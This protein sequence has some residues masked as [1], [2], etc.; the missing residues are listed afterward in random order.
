MTVSK[1]KTDVA[2]AL[3]PE[4]Q[5]IGCPHCGFVGQWLRERMEQPYC[6]H[7]G[8]GPMWLTPRQL[9]EGPPERWTQMVPVTIGQL[10]VT[11][12]MVERAWTYAQGTFFQQPA[13]LVR[14]MYPEVRQGYVDDMKR[15]LRECLTRA[16]ESE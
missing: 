9:E 8:Q 6:A 15:Q 10:Q 14:E 12:K 3:S 1:V 5:H 16:L 2:Q 7:N 4:W 11:E 13:A